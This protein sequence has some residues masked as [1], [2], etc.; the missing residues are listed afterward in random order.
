MSNACC[1]V[2][3]ISRLLKII[4]LFCRI[5]SLLRGSFSK[6]TYN[7]EEPTNR[8]HPIHLMHDHSAHTL[9]GFTCVCMCVCVCVSVSVTVSVSVWVCLHLSGKERQ[10]KK[11]TRK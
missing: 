9:F 1:G 11:K 2:A 7:F 5:K 10:R 8:S 6:E 3:M 4:G